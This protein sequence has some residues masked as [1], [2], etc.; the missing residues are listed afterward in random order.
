MTIRSLCL[1]G[2]SIYILNTQSWFG[3]QQQWKNNT[4]AKYLLVLLSV[5]WW[6][7]H[8]FAAAHLLPMPLEV[9]NTV[10]RSK[11]RRLRCRWSIKKETTTNRLNVFCQQCD[12]PWWW[13]S[14][15]IHLDKHVLNYGVRVSKKCCMRA[16]FIRQKACRALKR[17]HTDFLH[18]NLSCSVCTVLLRQMTCFCLSAANSS[19]WITHEAVHELAAIASTWWSV[20]SF[21]HRKSHGNQ[22]VSVPNWWSKAVYVCMLYRECFSFICAVAL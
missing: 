18:C 13:W 21:L 14:K 17:V 6:C 5:V 2:H 20:F 1:I 3:P 8:G 11:W 10:E 9:N 7:C 22:L 15:T 19:P 12:S 4:W 16:L